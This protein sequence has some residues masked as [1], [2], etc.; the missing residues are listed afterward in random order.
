MYTCEQE[1]IGVRNRLMKA[2]NSLNVRLSLSVARIPASIL[3]CS[4]VSRE[5]NFSSVEEITQLR[6]EQ[7][8]YL[9]GSCIEGLHCGV[10]PVGA[11]S[12][13]ELTPRLSYRMA[14]YLW[15]CHSWLD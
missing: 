9:E 3:K 7:R 2:N 6:L 4:A 14:V 5:I 12:L 8:I 13:H 10:R 1:G 15:L 11:L